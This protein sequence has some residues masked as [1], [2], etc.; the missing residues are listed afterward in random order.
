MRFLSYFLLCFFV[1]TAN[2]G[3]IA[4]KAINGSGLPV[5]RFV[6]T[7]SSRVNMRVGPG[8]NY[9]II[10]T[11]TKKAFPLKVVAEFD[12]WR[13]VQDVDGAEG[14]VHRSMVMPGRSVFFSEKITSF[15]EN[16]NDETPVCY[17][18]R[19]VVGTVLSEEK[20]GWVKVKLPTIKGW[21]RKKSLW[22][23]L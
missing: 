21:V 11:Y 19:G 23:I 8:N 5:P 3:A 9:K 18:E 2:S 20:Q 7:K 17:V 16:M 14:W 10:W 12:F 6:D 4:K 1:I 22:G 15:Y 13:K